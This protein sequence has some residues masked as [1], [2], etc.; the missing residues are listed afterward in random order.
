[1]RWHDSKAAGDATN[2]QVP[3]DCF[4]QN[5]LAQVA[6]VN[7]V[8]DWQHNCDQTKMYFEIWLFT[9]IWAWLA[10]FS[11]MKLQWSQR[12]DV[13]AVLSLKHES[14]NPNHENWCEGL[15]KTHVLESVYLTL[16]LFYMLRWPNDLFPILQPSNDN[17]ATLKC[18]VQKQAFGQTPHSQ[19][20]QSLT[21]AASSGLCDPLWPS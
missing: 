12:T 2:E 7:N 14:P 5:T 6:H 1:M 20:E 17:D 16:S 19:S 13:I 11:H 4:L 9:S 8:L 10:L 18:T 3:W 15:K 21:R